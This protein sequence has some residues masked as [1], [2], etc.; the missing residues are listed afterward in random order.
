[1]TRAEQ[2]KFCQICRHRKFDPTKGLI[3]TYTG[4]WANFSNHCSQY[5]EDETAVRN[6]AIFEQSRQS[7]NISED[8][9]FGLEKLGIKNGLLAGIL[10]LSIGITWLLGGLWYGVLF[11]YS[12]ILI[13]FGCIG[14][15]ISSIN[16][17]KKHKQQQNMVSYDDI[18]DVN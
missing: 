13:F 3:C 11:Y 1:M 7:I 6:Q 17:I 9:T 12:F 8:P 2:L 15:I 10:L 16:R 14:L 5:S 4:E 18:I